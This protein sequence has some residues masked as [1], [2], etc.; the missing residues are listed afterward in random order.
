MPRYFFDSQ[1]GDQLF[2][3]EHGTELVDWEEAR[4]EAVATLLGIAKDR[5]N[6]D[7]ATIEIREADGK[8]RVRLVV[9]LRITELAD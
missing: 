9:E 6:L 5:A 3:D 4:A 1:I 2:K 7:T 8:A